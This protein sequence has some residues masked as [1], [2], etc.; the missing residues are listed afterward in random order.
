MSEDFLTDA[1]Q[2]D[3]KQQQPRAVKKKG[4]TI[5]NLRSGDV[6]LRGVL[7][8]RAGGEAELTESQLKDKVLMKR[9]ENGIK[10][11]QLKE[12]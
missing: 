11:G 10:A 1:K 3:A 8:I 5:K 7:F 2:T 12:V 6:N 4:R 9:I